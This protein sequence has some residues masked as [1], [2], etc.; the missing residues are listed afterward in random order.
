MKKIMVMAT[1]IFAPEEMP[2]TKGPAMGLPKKFCS[3]KPDS[4][5]APP[6]IAAISIR[7]RRIFQMMAYCLASVARRS[8]IRA[9]SP[10]GMGTLP[11][12][13]FRIAA[14]AAARRAIGTRNGEQDT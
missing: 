6:R 4:D 9:I 7:G 8:N 3:R 11:M 13:M 10:I 14:C 5:S 12:L 2:S 1:T